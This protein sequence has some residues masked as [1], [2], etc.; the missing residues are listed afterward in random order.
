MVSWNHLIVVE[1]NRAVGN[2]VTQYLGLAWEV[3]GSLVGLSPKSVGS[4]LT[5]GRRCQ[6]SV[7]GHLAGVGEL[8]A[9]GRN[10]HIWSQKCSRSVECK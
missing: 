7:V 2:L 3:G 10:P 9:V 1:S 4:V 8:V 5:P 6:N